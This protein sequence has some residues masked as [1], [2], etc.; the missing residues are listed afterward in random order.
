MPVRKFRT[1]EEARRALWTRPGDPRLLQRMKGLGELGRR[2]GPR[3][4]GV[5]RYRSIAEAKADK[6]RH[7][8]D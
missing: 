2:M 6:D 5:F 8:Y 1:F 3:P 7:R 4:H